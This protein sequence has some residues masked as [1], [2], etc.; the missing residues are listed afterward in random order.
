VGFGDI[1][2]KYVDVLK[3]FN[4]QIGVLSR[5]YEKTVSKAKKFGIT[6]IFSS[7]NQIPMDEIDFFI[8]LVNPENNSKILKELI[9]FKKPI[10]VE[11][12][13]VFN[14][15]DLDDL[16]SD[17][18][19]FQTKV[20][21]AMNR[22]FYS[23]FNKALKYLE[24]KGKKIDSITIEAPERF[25][26]VNLPKFSKFVKEK[27]AF[28]NPI[29]CIDLIRFFG[30]DVTKI[31]VN[32]KLEKFSFSA[33]GHCEKNIEFT[34]ISNWKTPGSWS[35]CL[36]SDETKIFFSPL[37][38]GVII[39]KNNRIE[40]TPEEYDVELKPGFYM[41]IKYFFEEVMERKSINWPASDLKDNKK[42][43]ELIEQIYGEKI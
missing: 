13:V 4:C 38:K 22:R 16:I 12:P 2:P 27:W 8:I 33:I 32:R 42:T 15:K 25:T 10:L 20:M 11:K 31:D 26:D 43:V 9:P 7:V 1:A 5:N 19:K 28:S 29:H 14:S 30:G 35:V 39:E 41:Q 18:S 36:Y 17:N 21:V 34:Y 24:E 37:E 23:I 40:I 3:K 6:E